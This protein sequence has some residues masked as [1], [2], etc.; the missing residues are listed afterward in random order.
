M[1]D[2]E[3]NGDAIAAETNVGELAPTNG[4]G[5]AMGGRLDGKSDGFHTEDPFDPL[6]ATSETGLVS[7]IK[8]SSKRKP[9]MG[10]VRRW[11]GFN[12]AKY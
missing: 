9:R 2:A 12:R 8:K 1:H 7:N 10:Y 4:M 5:A 11:F 6:I 3:V